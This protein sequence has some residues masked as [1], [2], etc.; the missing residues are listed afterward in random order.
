[1]PSAD[2]VAT[3]PEQVCRLDKRAFGKPGLPPAWTPSTK[4]A[5]GTAYSTASRVWFTLA[6][7][8]I[9]ECYFPTIDHPQIRDIQFLVTDKGPQAIRQGHG[10]I[11][12][13]GRN[14]EQIWD[15]PDLPRMRMHLGKPTGSAMPLAWA[16]AEYIK[17]LRS[18]HDGGVFDRVSVAADRYLSSRGRRDLE[19]W[20][21][22]RQV[23]AVKPGETLR[24][25]APRR[26][27]LHW[28]GNEWQT[29]HNTDATFNALG[30]SFVDIPVA[31]AQSAPIRFTF[32]WTDEDHWEGKD[33]KVEIQ[34]RCAHP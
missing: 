8:I 22:I 28:T 17:L 26:F 14:P 21:P 30:I 9:T 32:F 15:A 18:V 7:G 33:Y 13:N 23:K 5:V 25:Q 29:V 12:L 19:I 2:F 24:I 10:R 1:M 16:H 6:D 3:S 31:H 27:R 34:R 20:K 11:R 4:E